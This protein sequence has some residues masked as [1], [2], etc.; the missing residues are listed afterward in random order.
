MW[1]TPEFELFVAPAADRAEFWRVAMSLLI[2]GLVYMIGAALILFAFAHWV[3]ELSIFPGS[4]SSEDALRTVLDMLTSIAERGAT[5]VAIAMLWSTF[6]P[7]FLAVWAMARLHGRGLAS[8][9]GR[10]RGFRRYFYL[11]ALAVLAI[12][13]PLL[14]LLGLG[15]TATLRVPPEIWL[16][17]LLWFGPLLLLQITT[18][19]LLFRG[20][21]QQQLGIRFRSPLMWMLI[22]S[23]LFGL[24]H[25]SGVAEGWFYVLWA[26]AFGLVAADLTRITGN[27]GAAMGLHLAHNFVVV[28]LIAGPERF[29]GVALF[30]LQQGVESPIPL[31]LLE[32]SYL[33]V[34]WAAIRLWLLRARLHFRPPATI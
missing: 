4:G 27:L 3:F 31:Q 29:D 1:R 9:F 11:A 8:L 2:A 17:H 12:N 7:L 16:M 30:H 13:L 32:L 18:E 10:R 25:L 14:W 19:E 6:L 34:L 26:T 5:P 23:V 21:L 22:P 28:A 33:V 15:S 24:C 20:Y